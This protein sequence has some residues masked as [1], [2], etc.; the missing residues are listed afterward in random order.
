[1]R[2]QNEGERRKITG[3]QTDVH[4][5]LN[6]HGGSDSRRRFLRTVAV[7]SLVGTVGVAGCLGAPTADGENGEELPE[8]VSEEQFRE[9]PVPE[10]YRTATSIGGERRDP[11]QLVAKS[12]VNFGEADEVAEAPEGQT[13]ANC[14]EF[15]ADKNGDGYGACTRV[16]GYIGAE[17]W[18]ELWESTEEEHDE[19]EESRR[20][21]GTAPSVD[22]AVI[23]K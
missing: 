9:G 2:R 23:E 16:E 3:L 8:G 1:M 18:C 19:E 13:C 6:G 14:H 21:D 15:V 17:D 4:G 11:N 12:A 7:T 5:R 22:R 10:A 20:F